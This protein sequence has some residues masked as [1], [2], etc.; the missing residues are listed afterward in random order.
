MSSLNNNNKKITSKVFYI[1]GSYRTV[2]PKQLAITAGIKEKDKIEWTLTT[3]NDNFFLIVK[4][5]D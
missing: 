2:I 3:N 1:N 4:K 5:V